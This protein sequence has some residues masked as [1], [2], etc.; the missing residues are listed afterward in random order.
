MAGVK[1]ACK[2]AAR[3]EGIHQYFMQFIIDDDSGC[4]VVDRKDNLVPSVYL[5][6]VQIACPAA[7][8]GIMYKESVIGACIFYKP[9]HC[10]QHILSRGLITRVCSVVSQHD[11]VR[12]GISVFL[13]KKPVYVSGVIHTSLKF[14]LLS[15]VIDAHANSLSFARA[16]RVPEQRM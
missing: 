5:V 15:G 4:L 14:V 7:M 13:Y 2:S 16:P 3:W 1:Y 8:S 11:N 6:A 12:M 10:I 9:S